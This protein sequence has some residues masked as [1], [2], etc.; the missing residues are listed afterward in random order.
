MI[1]RFRAEFSA[2]HWD[3][4]VGGRKKD[5]DKDESMAQRV[6]FFLPAYN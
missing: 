1:G 2:E 5:K 3:Q 4:R 6:D